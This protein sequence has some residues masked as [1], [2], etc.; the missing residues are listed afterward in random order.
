MSVHVAPA[1]TIYSDIRTVT[2]EQA[3]LFVALC[4]EPNQRE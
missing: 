4:C 3:Q 1:L 2:V